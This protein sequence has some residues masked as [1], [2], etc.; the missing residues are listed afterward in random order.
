MQ[1]GKMPQGGGGD[2]AEAPAWASGGGK[3]ICNG[4]TGAPHVRLSRV[5]LGLYVVVAAVE[6]AAMNDRESAYSSKSLI[7]KSMDMGEVLEQATRLAFGGVDPDLASQV[8]SS[9][10]QALDKQAK[11][12]A[13]VQ[14]SPEKIK[15]VP[16]PQ[17]KAQVEVELPNFD[18]LA[19]AMAQTAKMIDETARLTQFVQGKADSRPEAAGLPVDVLKALKD[20]Q[21]KQV[22]EWVTANGETEQIPD[23]D[24]ATDG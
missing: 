23:R 20:W 16:C 14:Y 19:K 7:A 3:E 10:L 2:L 18:A 12:L 4:I 21:L 22:L 13:A 11:T 15:R 1:R 24:R 5:Y 8:T 17:C 6:G 9:A